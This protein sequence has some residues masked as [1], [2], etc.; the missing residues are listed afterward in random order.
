MA[1]G[2]AKAQPLTSGGTPLATVDVFLDDMILTRIGGIPEPAT[3]ALAGLAGLV[4]V[5]A[6]RRLK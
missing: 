5:T 3:I 1:L 2:T 6:R 4:L